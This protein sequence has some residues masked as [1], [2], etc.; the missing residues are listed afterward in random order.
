ML[1]KRR[2]DTFIKIY[3]QKCKQNKNKLFKSK[4]KNI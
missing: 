1:D 3:S 2:V 4:V